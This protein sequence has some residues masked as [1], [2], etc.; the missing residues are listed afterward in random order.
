MRVSTIA[1]FTLATLTVAGAARVK[2]H[3]AILAE[4]SEELVTCS[5][6]GDDGNANGMSVTWGVPKKQC[7]AECGPTSPEGPTYQ[8]QF[9]QAFSVSFD[10]KCQ[11]SAQGKVVA[12]FTPQN[13]EQAQ[14]CTAGAPEM[15]KL[16][17]SMYQKARGTRF[18]AAGKLKVPMYEVPFSD[19]NFV[20]K[21]GCSTPCTEDSCGVMTLPGA[22]EGM[23]A[24]DKARV[25]KAIK[26]VMDGKEDNVDGAL[27]DLIDVL[28]EDE[29]DMS[30]FAAID[31]DGDGEL[32]V[33]ELVGFFSNF[34]PE[35]IKKLVDAVDADGNGQIG[36]DEFSA[37]KDQMRNS[38]PEPEVD[39]VSGGGDD[40]LPRDEEDEDFEGDS[41]PDEEVVPSKAEWV[42]MKDGMPAPGECDGPAPDEAEDSKSAY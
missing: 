18:V 24:E 1:T 12:A 10:K 40:V 23:D 41:V 5:A 35:Q 13:D 11:C 15:Q 22:L 27:L 7:M 32:S 9:T 39:I 8:K 4:A 31:I 29:I 38:D 37:F 34:K 19:S 17:W 3:D 21:R 2:A 33:E 28:P 6:V 26:D 30:E 16:C 14:Q 25:G 20:V 42:C 36:K